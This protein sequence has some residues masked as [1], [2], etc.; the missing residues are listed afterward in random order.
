MQ[1]LA[2]LIQK[3][4]YVLNMTTNISPSKKILD[5]QHFNDLNLTTYRTI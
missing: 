1:I 3:K 5:N 2:S 4:E